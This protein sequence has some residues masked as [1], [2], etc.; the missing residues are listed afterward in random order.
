MPLTEERT[1]RLSTGSAWESFR[2]SVVS[3]S[4]VFLVAPC[5]KHKCCLGCISLN[6]AIPLICFAEI[7]SLVFLSM[8][9][10]DF[11]ITDGRTFYTH[12]FEGYGTQISIGIIQ[13]NLTNSIVAET[14]RQFQLYVWIIFNHLMKNVRAKT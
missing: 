2:L 5:S 8:V 7:F 12:Y 4:K 14:L 10:L 1:S 13:M 6:D 3:F 11:Y 9:V